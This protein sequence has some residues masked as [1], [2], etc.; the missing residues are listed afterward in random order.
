L[1]YSIFLLPKKKEFTMKTRL[2]MRIDSTEERRGAVHAPLPAQLKS[3]ATPRIADARAAS[4]AQRRH[5]EEAGSSS[6]AAQL[7]IYAHMIAHQKGDMPAQRAEDEDLLQGKFGIAQREEDDTLLQAKFLPVQR[8][9]DED[10]LQG[11]FLPVQRMEKPNRTGLP[12][13]LK[14]G[15]EALSGMSMDHVK[16][17]YNSSKPA[18]LAAHAYAQGSEIHVAPGQEHHVPHEAWHVVQ[19]AQGRVQPTMQM[20][21]TQVN[22]DAGLEAE[23]DAMGAHAMHIGAPQSDLA[24]RPAALRTQDG[25][26]AQ[27]K[28]AFT[29]QAKK[30]SDD[31]VAA[32]LLHD[33]AAR[34]FTDTTLTWF[35][36]KGTVH[37]P[38]LTK[39]VGK[40]RENIGYQK[41]QNATLKN[42]QGLR[43]WLGNEKNEHMYVHADGKIYTGGRDQEKLPHPTLVGGDPD[44]TCAGTM[45]FDNGTKTVT[46]TNESGHF[47][48]KSVAG[49]TLEAVRAVLPKKQHFKV[50]KREV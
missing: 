5:L 44:A 4:V 39:L 23:A 46:V 12:N 24:A 49:A 36:A 37:K 35:T 2:S 21:G 45:S 25:S 42:A 26:A 31:H 8:D 17:H 11:K 13:Q 15:I 41:L 1:V 18:Q 47:R 16:V 40:E 27:R 48:P 29:I 22:D 34:L 20:A 19:Q 28:S 10:L 33:Q 38:T 50:E 3:A 32:D 43:S 30:V 9:E 6:Q 14:S 7:K